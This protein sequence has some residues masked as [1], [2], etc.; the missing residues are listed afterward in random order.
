LI[1]AET[2]ATA[3]GRKFEL[4]EYGENAVAW[5]QKLTE[6]LLTTVEQVRGYAARTPAP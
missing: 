6:A 5:K 3:W 2:G 4:G 1:D